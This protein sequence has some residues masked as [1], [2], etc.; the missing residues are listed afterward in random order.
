MKLSRIIIHYNTV[1]L[2]KSQL[3]NLVLNNNLEIIVIDNNSTQSIKDIKTAFPDITFIENSINYGYAFACN[4]GASI[5]NGEWLLFLN[6]DVGI[7]TDQALQLVENAENKKLDACSP[8]IKDP[9][10]QK[11]FPSFLSLLIEFT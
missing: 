10:Y 4:H 9:H 6:P 11:P 5:A 1:S 7:S 3:S 8:D 2:L